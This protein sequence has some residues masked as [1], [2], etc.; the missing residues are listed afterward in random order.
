M[1]LYIWTSHACGDIEK[2]NAE[3][4]NKTVANDLVFLKHAESDQ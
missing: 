4:E 1:I 2:E 3:Q